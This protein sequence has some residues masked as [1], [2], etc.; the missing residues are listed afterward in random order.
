MKERN[1]VT[2]L[3]YIIISICI[4]YTYACMLVCAHIHTQKTEEGREES[5]P[6]TKL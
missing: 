1:V 4:G 2:I 3:N 5:V 6:E